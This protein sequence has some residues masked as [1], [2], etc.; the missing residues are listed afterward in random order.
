MGPHPLTVGFFNFTI[1]DQFRVICINDK[2]RPV[3]FPAHLW[4]KKDQIYTVSEAKHLARQHMAVGYK[5]YEIEIPEDCKYQFFIA[6]RFRP[7]DED[8]LEAEKALEQL[9]L[10]TEEYA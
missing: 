2:F 8:E 6:N 10:E 1:M 3:D 9:L 7:V 5:F 4:I